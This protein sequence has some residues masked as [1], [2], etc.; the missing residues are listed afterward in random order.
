MEDCGGPENFSALQVALLDRSSEILLV[1][2]AI[3]AYVG[4]RDIIDE[5]GHILPCLSRGHYLSYENALRKNLVAIYGHKKEKKKQKLN[6]YI[7]AT[8]S[9][10][11]D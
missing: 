4:K 3:G 10:G 7:E 8:Y 9:E 11:N 2:M 1:L 5:D 6:D